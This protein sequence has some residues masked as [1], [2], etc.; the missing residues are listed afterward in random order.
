MMMASE[1]HK[2]TYTFGILVKKRRKTQE[3]EESF[4]NLV[5]DGKSSIVLLQR[6]R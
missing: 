4:F 1:L 2:Q 3:I 5:E 6:S